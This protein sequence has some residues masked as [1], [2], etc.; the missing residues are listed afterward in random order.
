MLMPLASDGA[1]PEMNEGFGEQ[2]Q[3]F[4]GRHQAEWIGWKQR[5]LLCVIWGRIAPDPPHEPPKS[6]GTFG[7]TVK[8]L[9]DHRGS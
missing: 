5:V 4:P 2:L 8:Y 3:D 7:R 6:P 9:S 1:I